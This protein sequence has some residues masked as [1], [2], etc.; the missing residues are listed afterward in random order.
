MT[1]RCWD[2]YIRTN[3]VNTCWGS[4]GPKVTDMVSSDSGWVIL[5]VISCQ[6]EDGGS[7]TKR[8]NGL[9]NGFGL[10]EGEL[11][12]DS[13]SVCLLLR[14]IDFIRDN[15]DRTFYTEILL[16]HFILYSIV[17]VCNIMTKRETEVPIITKPD[18]I[19]HNLYL[20]YRFMT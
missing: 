17:Y 10:G 14:E 15:Q 8:T 13:F 11:G 2:G 1:Q 20:N 18:K 9:S 3:M 12:N 7:D 6:G 4:K 16:V 5:S 19:S